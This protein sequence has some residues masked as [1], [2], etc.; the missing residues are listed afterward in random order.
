M[1][2]TEISFDKRAIDAIFR[3]LEQ[4]HLPG[5]A[6]GIAIAGVPKY[7]EAF[8]LANMELPVALSPQTRMR[9][10]SI[11]K[12]FVCLAYLLLCEEG[13]AGIDDPIG[14]YLPAMHAVTH[15]VTVR[16]LMSHTSGL[17]D[18]CDIRWFFSGVQSTVFAHDLLALYR[19][20]GDVN[21]SP[22]C[23]WCYNN[24][25]YQ[26]LSAVVE[27][28]A[29]QSIEDVLRK[30]IFEPAGMHDTFLRRLDVDF[31]PNSAT[32]HMLNAERVFEKT[33]LPG[34]LTGEGGI[35]STVADM[36]RWMRNMSNP[37][38]GT[39]GIWALMST[40]QKLIDGIE[41]GYGLGLFRRL[42]RGMD[43]V[44]HSGGGFGSNSQMIR[45]P[46]A[47]LDVF[48]VTNRSDINAS[49]LADTILTVCLGIERHSEARDGRCLSG[50]FRSP[51]TGR[52][53]HLYGREGRQMASI[54]GGEPV[55]LSWEGEHGLVQAPYS[56]LRHEIAWRGD[57]ITPSGIRCRFFGHCD[58]LLGVRDGPKSGSEPVAGDYRSDEIG[59]RVTVTED[60]EGGSLITEGKFGSAVYR[61]ERLSSGIWRI[62]SKADAM[63]SGI[64][65]LDPEDG[66]VLI[67]TPNTWPVRFRRAA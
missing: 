50:L 25:A 7:Q 3:E 19:E 15:R 39:P 43:V 35:V 1:S 51:T 4:S 44:S 57:A 48:V 18:V 52:V 63:W 11:T 56:S 21:F 8:G 20:I 60:A 58:E 59:V 42:Y 23:A 54:D 53:I 47:D 10:Y 61:L 67:R 38:V 22:G 17:H 31:V 16:Q 32:M 30:R 9:I 41:T 24:G 6:V 36:L 2:R 33:C 45:V 26:L 55:P 37:L 14:K 28:I 64:L 65:T 34:E 40:S 27:T 49:E 66:A 29:D 46:A 12:H 62:K 5:A 13:K